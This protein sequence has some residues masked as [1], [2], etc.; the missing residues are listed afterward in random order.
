[1]ADADFTILGDYGKWI[2]IVVLIA[3]VV[4]AFHE[5]YTKGWTPFKERWITPRSARRKRLEALFG[6]CESLD[7]SVKNI[8]AQLRPNGG[9]T[10]TDK[11][12]TIHNKVEYIQS[13]QRYHEETSG[14]AT[15]DLDQNGRM[16]Y[17]SSKLCCLLDVD[18]K[19]LLHRNWISRA[20]SGE[21]QMLI[22]E[23]EDA[24][25]NK[26]PLD[27]STTFNCGPATT[28]RMRLSA[29]PQVRSGGELTGYFGRADVV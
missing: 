28:I 29:V 7:A 2:A 15:F 22:R 4:K 10:L 13:K 24:I 19:E 5:I 18:E 3:G 23:L 26:M 14:I 8:E 12:D 25:A 27:V 6:V 11:V 16:T 20:V 1:M 17:A 21:K 9:S